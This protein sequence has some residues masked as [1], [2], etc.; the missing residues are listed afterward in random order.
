M[1][2]V[3][4]IEVDDPKKEHPEIL[5]SFIPSQRV[6]LRLLA[7]WRKRYPEAYLITCMRVRCR[8]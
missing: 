2:I 8:V 7:K 6:A 5:N 4:D 1:E 3:Y